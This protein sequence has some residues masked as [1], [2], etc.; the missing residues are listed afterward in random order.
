MKKLAEGRML[1]GLTLVFLSKYIDKLYAN[2]KNPKTLICLN[3]CCK[4]LLFSL[5]AIIVSNENIG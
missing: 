2:T 3:I 4:I 5:I 1:P